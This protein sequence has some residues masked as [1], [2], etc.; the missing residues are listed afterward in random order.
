VDKCCLKQAALFYDPKINHVGETGNEKA[1]G[2]V[3]A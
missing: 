1:A 3:P 2:Q